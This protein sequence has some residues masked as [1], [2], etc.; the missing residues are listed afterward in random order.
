M[1]NNDLRKLSLYN[2]GNSM[3][4]YN[5]YNSVNIANQQVPVN[6]EDGYVELFVFTERGQFPVPGALVTIYA[7]QQDGDVPIKRLTTQSYPVTIILPVA[8]PF[9]SLIRGPEYYFTTYNMTIEAEG[10]SIVRVLNLRIFPRITENF[11]INLYQIPE[12]STLIPE[13]IID[14]PP[15]PR[16]IVNDQD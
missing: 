16:D 9:G 5:N 10:F 8:N 14:I 6:Q 4:N 3:N 15:H 1:N 11:D 12:G 7:R 13:K 2:S